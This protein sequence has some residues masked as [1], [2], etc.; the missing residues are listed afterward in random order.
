MK[1]I[2]ALASR[3]GPAGMLGGIGVRLMSRR[4][5]SRDS[6]DEDMWNFVHSSGD[7]LT[8]GLLSNR[9]GIHRGLF[10]EGIPV[11]FLKSADLKS[12]RHE[13]KLLILPLPISMSQE[14]IRDVSDY[15][16]NGGPLISG[17]F[18]GRFSRYGVASPGE[19]PRDVI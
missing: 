4:I 7:V 13:Y 1:E 5:T 19:L 14:L 6:L 12:R 16:R 3:G 17:P 8:S 18:P 2:N 10:Q 15:L 11:D 9:R